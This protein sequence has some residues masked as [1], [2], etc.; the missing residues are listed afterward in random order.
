MQTTVTIHWNTGEVAED[1]NMREEALCSRESHID[2]YN[3][4]GD[5]SHEIWLH[6][7]MDEIYEIEFR[8]ALDEYNAKQ[9]RSDR[10]MS[11]QDYMKSVEDDN[12]GKTQT[13]RVNGKRVVNED[14]AR[15]GKQ[16]SYEFTVKV[17]NTY[18]AKD[19]DGR[20]QYDENNHHVRPE[21]LPRDLQKTILKRYYET[22]QDANPNLRL[23]GFYYHGDE[24]FYNKRQEW[25][26]SEDHGH[27][28]VIPVAEGFKR[29][30]SKQN[31]MNKAM[32]A[33]G[34][35]TPDCYTEWADKEQER[36]EQITYEEYAKYCEA[37]PEFYKEHGDLTIYHP[38][39]DKTR[40]GGKSKEEFAREQELDESISE[41]EHLVKRYKAK[42]A[43][44]DKTLRYQQA[45]I[46]KNGRTIEAQEV[47]IAD[48]QAEA[49]EYIAQKKAEADKYSADKKAEADK[50][51]EKLVVIPQQ[52]LDAEYEEIEKYKQRVD[53][54]QR[55][56]KKRFERIDSME[57]TNNEFFDYV[58]SEK[59]ELFKEIK[60]SHKEYK[61][62]LKKAVEIQSVDAPQRSEDEL[63]AQARQVIQH[64]KDVQG[65]Y[66][67][68]QKKKEQLKKDAIPVSRPQQERELPKIKKAPSEY[69]YEDKTPS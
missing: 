36:L 65:E 22:F 43:G 53:E 33:M 55:D 46:E 63:A 48:T 59:P 68:M 2:Y 56:A 13:K 4:H 10:K 38:V 31:S 27:V 45:E 25:E 62:G 1:H 24:G 69:D 39:E 50:Q 47:F 41:A 3:E 57:L 26:Y 37:N 40:D 23:K 64:Y 67:E 14:A 58:K 52:L 60:M 7:D 20:T 18:R 9:R 30:L 49:D 29:G 34:F 11:M 17:G 6:H 42:V 21:E 54:L 16:L 28:E 12:R 32:R 61:E 5:S 35:D 15:Q 51:F 8:D 44:N 66:E 19:D